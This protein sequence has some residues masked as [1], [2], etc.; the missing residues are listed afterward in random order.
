MGG[1]CVNSFG[2]CPGHEEVRRKIEASKVAQQAAAAAETRANNLKVENEALRQK[3]VS[4]P[5]LMV[6]DCLFC[7]YGISIGLLKDHTETY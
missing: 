2:A 3:V 5:D 4:G 1:F 7:A 6:S